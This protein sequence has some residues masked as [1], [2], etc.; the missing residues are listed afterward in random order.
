MTNDELKILL[1]EL[2]SFPSET[3]WLEFKVNNTQEIGQY[4]SALSNSACVHG[5]EYGYIIYGIDDKSHR[6]VGT[7]FSPYQKGKGNEDLIPWVTRKLS[8]RIHF[9]HFEFE[10]EG[11]PVVIFRVKATSNTPVKYD[12]ETYIR[13]GSAPQSLPTL[14]NTKKE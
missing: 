13:I 3:E 9:E 12:G 8:P 2:R 10:V 14:R 7:T 4:I 5:K 6:I 1:S 11:E